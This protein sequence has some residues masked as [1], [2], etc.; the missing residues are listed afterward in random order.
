[1][2]ADAEAAKTPRGLDRL[3][4]RERL[5]VVRLAQRIVG[6]PPHKPTSRMR[7]RQDPICE[8]VRTKSTG[9]QGVIMFRK[10][11]TLHKYTLGAV[12][13]EIGKVKDFYFDD[14][15]WTIRYLVADTGSWLGREE[16]LVLISP[17][18]LVAVDEER[19]AIATNLTRKQV[20]NSPSADSDKPVS[21]QFETVY[22]E[23]YGWPGYWSGPNAWGASRYPVPPTE[24]ANQGKE[25]SWDSHL[26]S[27]REVEGYGVGAVDGE[28]G[29]I[30]DF[31]I[32]EKDW[33][34]RYLVVDTR[35]WLPG[36]HVLLSPQ[37]IE[38][39]SW[40]D[41]KVY[42][43]LGRDTIKDAPEYAKDSVI[44]REYETELCRHYNREGYWTGDSAR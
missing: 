23:Y 7:A 15:Y 25:A 43:N 21:R 32:D 40:D 30:A 29:H 19:E 28:I 31:I 24:G 11:E 12:D 37:W 17:Y 42:V 3:D 8:P 14:R 6:R 36:K 35:N 20:E 27:V 22:H 39:V 13:G 4:A 38:R 9:R 18:A 34:I 1:M 10:A 44:S 5:A 2:V 16:R 26:R 33:A 41:R